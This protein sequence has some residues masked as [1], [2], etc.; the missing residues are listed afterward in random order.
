MRRHEK[1]IRSR[2]EMEEIISRSTVCRLAMTDGDR[3]YLVPL[4]FGYR[5]GSLFFH[6]ALQGRKVDILKRNPNVCFAFDIDQEVTAA[7]RVCGWSMR[8]RSVVGFGKARIVEEEDDK[9]KALEI[10]MENYSAGEHSFD[11]SEVS[12]VLIIRVDIEEMTGKKSG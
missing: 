1:Q 12:S 11:D 9:R 6:S 8:Y 4:C 3:P 5:N 10:I 7:E 2:P